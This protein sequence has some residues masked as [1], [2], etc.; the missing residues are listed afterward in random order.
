MARFLVTLR[1]D[2][3]H[4]QTLLP[5]T[6]STRST[7]Q[8]ENTEDMRWMCERLRCHGPRY[9]MPPCPM[10]NETEH[11]ALFVHDDGVIQ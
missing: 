2:L 4:S 11:G 1:L 8:I 10:S 6:V 3:Q 7:T 9:L 5:L